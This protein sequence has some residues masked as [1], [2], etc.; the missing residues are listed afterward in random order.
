MFMSNKNYSYQEATAYKPNTWCDAQDNTGEWRLGRV[1]PGGEA[2]SFI[3][4]DK[5]P[6]QAVLDALV[7]AHAIT[8]VT[9]MKI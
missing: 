1:A 3:N 8:E 9:L 4:V 5:E 6:P 2:L 7:Q